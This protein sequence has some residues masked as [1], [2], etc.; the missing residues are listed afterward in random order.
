MMVFLTTDYTYSRYLQ[1]LGL[2]AKELM[3]MILVQYL[4]PEVRASSDSSKRGV[5]EGGLFCPGIKKLFRNP[6]HSNL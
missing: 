2:P 4:N 6:S 3:M 5:S 1:F